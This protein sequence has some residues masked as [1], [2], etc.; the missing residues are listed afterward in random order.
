[1]LRTLKLL[2]LYVIFSS[3]YLHAGDY[4]K[5]AKD[6]LP[7]AQYE[8][9]MSLIEKGK[10][11]IALDWFT[12]AAAQGHLKSS[13]WIEHNVD[14]RKDE[15]ITAL[16]ATNEELK[17]KVKSYTFDELEEIKKNG[18]AGDADTQF[19]LWLLYVNDI[20]ITKPKAYVWIKKAAFNKQPRAK[21]G[22]GLLYYYGYIVPEQKSKAIKLFEE[23]SALGYRFA[24]TF[25]NK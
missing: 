2:I 8:Y 9:A 7:K 16:I 5:D 1:M 24:S 11:N 3:Q 25:L 17:D 20:S 23:S 18:K 22:L 15:F 4:I 6:G 14:Y 19:L 21:F 10:K 12:I 13:L